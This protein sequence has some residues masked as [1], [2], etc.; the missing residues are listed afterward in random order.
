MIFCTIK[1]KAYRCHF[2]PDG[3]TFTDVNDK[4]RYIIVS[5]DVPVSTLVKFDFF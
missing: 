1:G 2:N 4:D 5:L 3:I